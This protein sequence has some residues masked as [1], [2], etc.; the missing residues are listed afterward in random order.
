[1][2]LEGSD[3]IP[4]EGLGEVLR[5]W[6]GRGQLYEALAVVEDNRSEVQ[7]QRRD[8]EGRARRIL[9]ARLARDL[10]R[11]PVSAVD[12]LDALPAQ[13]LRQR[14]ITDAPQPGTDWIE[15]RTLGWPPEQFVVKDR[16]RVADQI[17]AQTLRWVID[18]LILI[19]QDAVRIE[20]S[21]SAVASP[22]LA[23]AF[24][25]RRH[26]PLSVTEGVRP[27]PTDIRALR[28]S[29]RPWSRLAPVAE[30]LTSILSEDLLDF[31]R[32]HLFPDEDLRWRLFH[33]AAF[34]QLIRTLRARGALIT[35]LRPLSGAASPGPA[36]RVEFNDRK[37]DLWFEASAIWDYYNKASPY[38]TLT[39]S[40]LTHQATP[41]GADILFISPGV[42]CHAFECK[43]GEI[44]YI[45]RNGYLQVCTYAHELRRQLVNQ[46]TAR[47][48][49]PDVKVI[50]PAE[51]RWDDLTIGIIGPRHFD[52]LEF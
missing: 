7:W 32:Q 39:R 28:R 9:L 43:F 20:R 15:T 24:S 40:A 25:L 44:G 45:A 13:S 51:M 19:R 12:W 11:W 17:L 31:A 38:Q 52:S 21:L 27:T 42:E 8:I 30:A 35:S 10:E 1:M 6:S 37:W 22:Q 46:V 16:N 14:R 47:V 48:V 33:L 23:A 18:Q 36:Y 2:T 26:V 50:N 49:A 3:E 29:G 41:L 34:G 5:G 4:W